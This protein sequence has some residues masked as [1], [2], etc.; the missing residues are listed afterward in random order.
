MKKI[1]AVLAVAAVLSGCY[2]GDDARRALSAQGFSDV[3]VT[4]H[5]W[6][7]CGKDD[8]YATSFTATNSQG[9]RVSGAVCS[10]FMFKNSTVRW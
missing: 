8:F 3:E 6:F 1:I 2:N 9:K 7:A 4:G 5:A 10:G